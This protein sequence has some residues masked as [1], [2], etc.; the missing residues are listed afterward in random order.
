MVVKLCDRLKV[1]AGARAD[2][3]GGTL[4]LD[5]SVAQ[6]HI[7]LGDNVHKLG[8]HKA[9]HRFVVH[10]VPVFVHLFQHHQGIALKGGGQDGGVGVGLRAEAEGIGIDC[11]HAHTGGGGAH[12]AQGGEDSGHQR[13]AQIFLQ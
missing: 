1:G 2:P 8:G 3:K 10:L 4:A 13:E 7:R 11:A 5:Q 6:V 9:F 12:H